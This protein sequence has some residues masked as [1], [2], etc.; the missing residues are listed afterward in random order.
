MDQL[1]QLDQL[2]QIKIITYLPFFLIFLRN[3]LLQ[4]FDQTMNNKIVQTLTV[5]SFVKKEIKKRKLDD[6]VLGL[7]DLIDPVDPVDPKVNEAK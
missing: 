6:L 2:D 4:T 7:F 3:F 1:D 5:Q